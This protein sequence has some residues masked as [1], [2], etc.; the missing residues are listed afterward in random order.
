MNIPARLHII[1]N[2]YSNR[3]QLKL[4]QRDQR[5]DRLR[6]IGRRHLGTGYTQNSDVAKFDHIADVGAGF[7][8]SACG[9][10]ERALCAKRN[11]GDSVRS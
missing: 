11:F 5:L 9:K 6:R 7:R 4:P 3:S 2:F 1:H 8:E 10:L